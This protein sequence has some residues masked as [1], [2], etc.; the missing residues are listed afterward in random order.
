M[1]GLEVV[2]ECVGGRVV[3]VELVDAVSLADVALPLLYW[4]ASG[5]TEP[6]DDSEVAVSLG[7]GHG[8]VRCEIQYEEWR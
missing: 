5:V 6:F 3:G 7:I 8:G 4:Q 1:F 2:Q